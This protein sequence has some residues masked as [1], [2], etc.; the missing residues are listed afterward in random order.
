MVST[1]CA[2]IDEPRGQPRVHIVQKCELHRSALADQTNEAP[3]ARLS[4][5]AQRLG[6]EFKSGRLHAKLLQDELCEERQSGQRL[7]QFR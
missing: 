4:N 5:A 3:A 7:R 2:E 1:R 6:G